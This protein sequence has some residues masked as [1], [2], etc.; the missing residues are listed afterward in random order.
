MSVLIASSQMISKFISSNSHHQQVLSLIAFEYA[1]QL[2]IA[3]YFSLNVADYLF[4]LINKC[5]YSNHFLTIVF[6]IFN[7]CAAQLSVSP[8]IPFSICTHSW[9]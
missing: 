3:N 2:N 6:R 4:D 1:I 7:S 9:L 8:A 5:H